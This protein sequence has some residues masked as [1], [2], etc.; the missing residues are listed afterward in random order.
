MHKTSVFPHFSLSLQTTAMQNNIS[1]IFV[2]LLVAGIFFGS[3]NA[4]AQ[5]NRLSPQQQETVTQLLR[6]RGRNSSVRQQIENVIDPVL[7]GRHV[8]FSTEWLELMGNGHNGMVTRQQFQ[9][10]R[11]RIDRLYECFEKFVG[12]KPRGGDKI[13]IDLQPLDLERTVYMERYGFVPSGL[14]GGGKITINT[15]NRDLQNFVDQQGIRTSSLLSFTMMHEL[16]HAFESGQPWVADSEVAADFLVYYALE[17]GGFRTCNTK[18]VFYQRYSRLHAIQKNSQNV[19]A[20]FSGKG[21]NPHT[22][23]HN[24]AYGLFMY[25]LVDEVGWETFRR[26]IQSYHNGTF[27]PIRKYAPNGEK[28][29]TTKH[30][31]A[32]EFFDR[33]AHFY[34]DAGVLRRGPD[35][36]ALLDKHFTVNA[37]LIAAPQQDSMKT[38]LAGSPSLSEPVSTSYRTAFPTIF[39]A[40]AKGRVQDVEDFVSRN[41]AIIHARDDRQNT[42]LHHAAADNR[43][44]DVLKFLVSR[45]ADVNA[46]NNVG[47]TSLHRAADWNSNI[48]ILRYLIDAGADVHATNKSGKTPLG[49]ANPHA[50]SK[51]TILRAAMEQRRNE[52]F[53][54]TDVKA[55]TEQ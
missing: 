24:N 23:R 11:D 14:F 7:V 48:E 26:T 38:A 12:H 40:A 10:Y 30:V 19:V 55:S 2:L 21:K 54:I 51:R 17:N 53:A 18:P 9:A 29:Q 39:E 6:E 20:A 5:N 34:G 36:G 50:T 16:A 52:Q 35:K 32:H 41:P 43:N 15:G 13:F 31:R 1:P 8:V 27:T 33:L 25:G 47:W 42:P 44:V 28:E 3:N 22:N 37:T 49:V 46:K 45:G 4:E